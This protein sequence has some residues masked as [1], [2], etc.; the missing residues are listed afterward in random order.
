LVQAIL[1]NPGDW[2]TEVFMYDTLKMAIPIYLFFASIFFMIHDYS[3]IHVVHQDK[4]VLTFPMWQSFGLVFK[5]F[6]PAF[7]LYLLNLLTV[8][9]LLAAYLFLNPSTTETE[10]TIA[11]SFAIGQ[12]FIF[13]RIGTKLLNLGSANLLYQDI[14]VEKEVIEIE[15]K[16]LPI[17]EAINLTDEVKSEAEIKSENIENEKIIREDGLDN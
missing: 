1:G 9:G 8:I 13:A 3:K 14:M 10:S 12:A 5:N 7:F 16:E 17:A 11:L 4:G 2:D 6:F 15:A